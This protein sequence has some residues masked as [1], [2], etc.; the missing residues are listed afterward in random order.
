MA[1]VQEGNYM[2]AIQSVMPVLGQAT[3]VIMNVIN[4][5]GPA[6]EKSDIFGQAVD[7]GGFGSLLTTFTNSLNG[8]PL[9]PRPQGYGYIEKNDA[10][11]FNRP[12]YLGKVIGSGLKLATYLINFGSN[13]IRARDAGRAAPGFDPTAFEATFDEEIRWLQEAIGQ[14]NLAFLREW[15][16]ERLR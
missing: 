15:V 10:D 1:A 2:G 14:E 7:G 6:I 8:R 12:F 9:P 5:V 13:V 11:D 16:D 3:P 4:T